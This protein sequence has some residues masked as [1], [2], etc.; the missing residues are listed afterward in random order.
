MNGIGLSLVELVLWQG[1]MLH[2]RGVDIQD[3]TFIIDIKPCLARPDHVSAAHD[4]WH[5]QVNERV[6]RQLI[7][8][9]CS[10]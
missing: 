6:A 10:A 3:G 2:L 1:N 8:Y 9:G 7:K 5:G 4:S